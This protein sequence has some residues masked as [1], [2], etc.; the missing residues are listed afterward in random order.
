MKNFKTVRTCRNCNEDNLI[1]NSNQVNCTAC[2]NKYGKD[3]LMWIWKRYKIT[4]KGVEILYNKQKG[5]CAIC[6]KEVTIE[7]GS[8]PEEQ[9]CIDHDHSTGKI[10]GILCRK[11]N[12]ALGQLGDSLETINGVV[13]YLKGE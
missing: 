13:L 10:R 12:R 8:N 1:N 3:R 11:C 4:A 5:K 2:I 9:A 7:K 6:H